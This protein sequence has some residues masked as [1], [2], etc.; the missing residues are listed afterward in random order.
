MLLFYDKSNFSNFNMQNSRLECHV[1]KNYLA[2]ILLHL[3]LSLLYLKFKQSN[4]RII[5][6][7]P[8]IFDQ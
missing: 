5:S 4:K 7:I 6:Y 1:I 2:Q 8:D 3:I